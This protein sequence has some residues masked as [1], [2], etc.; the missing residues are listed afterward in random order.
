MTSLTALTYTAPAPALSTTAIAFYS[1]VATVIPVLFLAL[2]VTGTAYKESLRKAIAE[3]QTKNDGAAGAAGA[4]GGGPGFME[5]L[6][7]L[8]A[9]IFVAAGLVGE[10]TAV[11]VLYAGTDGGDGS[12]YRLI[13]LVTTLVLLGGVVLGPILDYIKASFSVQK[14]FLTGS[15]KQLADILQQLQQ[16]STQSAGTATG[17]E[18]GPVAEPGKKI[19]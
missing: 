18:A 14:L 15:I 16:A 8:G 9:V 2:A 10:A 1:A 13:A 11:I 6:R 12:A 7:V 19:K 5:L 4:A 3:P 17:S